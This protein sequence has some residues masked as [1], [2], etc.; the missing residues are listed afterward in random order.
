MYTICLLLAIKTSCPE[1]CMLYR[2]LEIGF[3]KCHDY[4]L[5][6]ARNYKLYA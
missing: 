3:M 5:Y 1:F 4:E 2:C 6:F